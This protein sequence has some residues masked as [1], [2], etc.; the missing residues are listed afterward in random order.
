MKITLRSF[1][2]KYYRN[3]NLT[4]STVK[5]HYLQNLETLNQLIIFNIQVHSTQNI[6][7]VCKSVGESPGWSIHHRAQELDNLRNSLQSF[8]TKYLYLHAYKV[9]II[10]ELKR[11]DHAEHRELIEWIMEQQQA[12]FL[13][14][15]VFTDN[16]SLQHDITFED[17]KSTGDIHPQRVTFWCLFWAS[18]VLLTFLV[19]TFFT[20][21]FNS[22]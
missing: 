11:T 2:A 21:V 14:H 9:Q 17:G 20:L 1:G 15:I 6:K 18:H 19:S 5:K 8:R 13:N 12:N 7:A 3:R 10:Q 4:L 22:H 16:V